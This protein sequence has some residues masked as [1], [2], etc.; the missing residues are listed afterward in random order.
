MTFDKELHLHQN[1]VGKMGLDMS[2]ELLGLPPHP[3]APPNIST[4]KTHRMMDKF[5]ISKELVEELCKKPG[6]MWDKVWK[7][8]NEQR[9]RRAEEMAEMDDSSVPEGRIEV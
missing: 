5:H 1:H 2:V 9:R 6:C 4:L 3:G 7:K 8:S